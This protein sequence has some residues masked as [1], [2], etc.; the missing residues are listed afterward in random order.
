MI[1][2]QVKQFS[3]LGGELNI[4][5]EPDLKKINIFQGIRGIIRRNLKK[6]RSDTQISFYK[7]A[8]LS[9]LL[10]ESETLVTIKREENRIEAAEKR[11]LSGVKR[12][13]C[14]DKLR[15]KDARKQ[16]KVSSIQEIG[17]RYKQNWIDHS[18]EWMVADSR[19]SSLL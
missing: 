17:S 11:S 19:M 2:E 9:P 12:C 13:A 15:S 1:L 5:E 4:D 6:T 18:K 8:T 3:Y 7:V 14:L 10:Y 16:L